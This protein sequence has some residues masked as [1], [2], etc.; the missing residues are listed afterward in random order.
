MQ[1]LIDGDGPFHHLF[2]VFE[3]PNGEERVLKPVCYRNVMGM[4]LVVG[5]EITYSDI[6]KQLASTTLWN[7]ATKIMKS[8]KKAMTLVPRLAPKMIQLDITKRIVGYSSGINFTSFIEAINNGMYAMGDDEEFVRASNKN[9]DND[10]DADDND[11]CEILVKN[12][13]ADWDPFDGVVAPENVTFFGFITFALLGPGAADP[14]HFSPLL[15]SNSNENH[16]R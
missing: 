15:R 10:D 13:S 9:D 6:S 2:E 4:S 11:S 5:R 7:L 8:C 3:G 1:Q 16:R 12:S 14:A